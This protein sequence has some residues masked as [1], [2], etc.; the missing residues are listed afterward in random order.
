[1]SFIRTGAPARIIGGFSLPFRALVLALELVF[2]R[3]ATIPPRTLFQ[4]N[5]ILPLP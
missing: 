1:M 5:I 2:F 4:Q 3:S